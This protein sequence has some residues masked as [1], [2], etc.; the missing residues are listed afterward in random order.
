MKG[1]YVIVAEK[2]TANHFSIIQSCQIRL[3]IPLNSYPFV[4]YRRNLVLYF[5]L[6]L[7]Q[8]STEFVF[9]PLV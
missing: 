4:C 9:G 5:Q 3:E 7:L 2:K 6:T 1:I 8:S